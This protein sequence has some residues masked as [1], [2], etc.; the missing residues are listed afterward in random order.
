MTGLD[1]KQRF[2][3]SGIYNVILEYALDDKPGAVEVPVGDQGARGVLL[4]T[5][6][7]E[8]PCVQ[9]L[10]QVQ[11]RQAGNVAVNLSALDP[12]K[13]VMKF[14]SIRLVR[15]EA[16]KLEEAPQRAFHPATL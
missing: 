5:E 1:G 6:S 11:I 14:R 2:S 12:G 16:T 13:R 10:G 9:L 3:S 4:G 7:W 8:T 15:T